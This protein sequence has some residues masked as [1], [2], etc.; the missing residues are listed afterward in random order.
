MDKT[1]RLR[2]PRLRGTVSDLKLRCPFY[3][4]KWTWLPG[5]PS[6]SESSL[7]AYPHS[8]LCS[9][10][11]GLALPQLLCLVYPR[12][13][14]FLILNLFSGPPAVT[15]AVVD[16]SKVLS[17][18]LSDAEVKWGA[19]YCAPPHSLPPPP[20]SFSALHVVILAVVVTAAALTDSFFQFFFF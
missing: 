3:T 10:E 15:E 12:P 19:L 5:S 9:P 16:L 2:V 8:E 20:G 4:K 18:V 13:F 1:S 6:I 17:C 11:I 7:L 14:F